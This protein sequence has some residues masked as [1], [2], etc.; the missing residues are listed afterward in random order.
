MEENSNKC[1]LSEESRRRRQLFRQKARTENDFD[2]GEMC[3]V[4]LDSPTSPSR[5]IYKE[6]ID[7]CS[8]PGKFPGPEWQAKSFVYGSVRYLAKQGSAH[9]YNRS[10]SLKL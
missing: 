8:S 5:I 7:I 2:E 3:C 10:L 6:T 1:E 9:S 4:L